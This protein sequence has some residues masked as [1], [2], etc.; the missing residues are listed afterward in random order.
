VE[1]Q[2]HIELLLPHTTLGP[3]QGL[4]FVQA[5]KKGEKKDPF[6]QKNQ[7]SI[8]KEK[9]KGRAK[10]GGHPSRRG[11]NEISG[12]KSLQGSPEKQARK[13]KK[14]IAEGG[15]K[16]ESKKVFGNWFT[17]ATNQRKRQLGK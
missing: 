7:G 1:K 2:H 13:R 15:S 17:P 9:K 11:N 6:I 10:G 3:E 8:K 12:R 5:V 14:A 4:D 16:P